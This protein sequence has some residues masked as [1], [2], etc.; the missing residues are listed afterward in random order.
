MKNTQKLVLSE[1][2]MK[3]LLLC[4][5]I[6]FSWSMIALQEDNIEQAIDDFARMVKQ[7]PSTLYYS[8]SSFNA[9]KN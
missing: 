8:V 5:R 1:A 2:E 4:L 6:R 9:A 3:E 7:D